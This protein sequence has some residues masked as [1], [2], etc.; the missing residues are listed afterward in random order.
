MVENLGLQ[1]LVMIVAVNRAAAPGSIPSKN[2]S[3]FCKVF[4][5]RL[6]T[7]GFFSLSF[8]VYLASK[9]SKASFPSS[10]SLKSSVPN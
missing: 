2:L 5:L 9:L 3:F 10:S 4:L 7:S 6:L 1:S 8:P